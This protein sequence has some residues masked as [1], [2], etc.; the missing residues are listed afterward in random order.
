MFYHVK[1]V[2]LF[3]GFLFLLPLWVH[4]AP[5]SSDQ[6]LLKQQQQLDLQREQQQRR[7]DV[8]LAPPANAPLA[9]V[10]PSAGP[11]FTVHRVQLDGAPPDWLA[12]LTPLVRPAEGRCLNLGAINQLVASLTDA[13]VARGFVTSRVYVP[14]QNLQSGQLHLVLLPGRI[15]A[16]RRKGGSAMR[17]LDSAFPS[18]PGDLLNVRDLEQGLEQLQRP[19]SQQASM[20]LLPGDTPGASI[21]EV[22]L[23]QTRPLHASL[24]VEN[25]GQTATGKNQLSAQVIADDLLGLNDVLTINQSQDAGAFA[26][27]GSLAQ[28]FSWLAPWG[29]WS[30]YLSYNA[31]QYRQTIDT[32]LQELTSTG[33]SRNTQFTLTRLLHRDQTSKTELAFSMT[34]KAARSYL[35]D[36]ELVTQ[37]QDL[38][39]LG[40]Q[41]NHR[42][43]LGASVL[44]ASLGY[45]RG[46]PLW[47]AQANS[48]AAQGGPS[49][50]PEIY[51]ASLDWRLPW[52][53]G[54]QQ[55]AYSV[56]LKGQYSPNL[57]YATDQFGVGG[58]YTV[59][60][61]DADSLEG[62][63]GWLWRNELSWSLGPSGWEA[64]LGLDTGQVGGSP[65]VTLSSQ[66]IAGSAIGL[67]ANLGRHLTADLTHEQAL[68]LPDG[69]VRQSITHFNL[70]LQW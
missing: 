28:S 37:R 35:E 27:L 61:F 65:G 39:Y 42:H 40:W 46:V 10:T 4:A 26:H 32:G 62:N 59:R 41:L 23:T 21:V 25:S 31:S 63:N 57:L 2:R 30:A 9:P 24:S 3:A 43:Y 1:P 12:W 13:I 45:S 68:T 7:P 48:L 19:G 54:G 17:E 5:L 66:R 44:N 60:G 70:T 18:G 64:Y 38:T 56:S 69:W 55:G 22:T 52:L 29:N 34:R 15:Q 49:A 67:R 53:V 58:H 50:R 6:I 33:H 16:I 47:G 36:S 20:A 51:S 14:E 11:C 8:F